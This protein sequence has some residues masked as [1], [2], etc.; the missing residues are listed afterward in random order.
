M[1]K[2]NLSIVSQL[3]CVS[4]HTHKPPLK[5]LIFI[6]TGCLSNHACLKVFLSQLIHHLVEENRGDD[7]EAQ[8]PPIGVCKV[9]DTKLFI[10]FCNVDNFKMYNANQNF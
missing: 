1:T 5:W 4:S 6:S 7:Q 2:R 10:L 9:S 8:N 3:M